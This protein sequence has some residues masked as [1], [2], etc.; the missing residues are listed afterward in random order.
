MILLQIKSKKLTALTTL[1]FF[2]DE[3]QVKKAVFDFALRN[4]KTACDADG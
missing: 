1:I 2:T 3:C 4:K